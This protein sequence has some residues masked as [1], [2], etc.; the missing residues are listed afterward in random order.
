MYKTNYLTDC[1]PKTE[2]WRS[3]L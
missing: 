2:K 1:W 3:T